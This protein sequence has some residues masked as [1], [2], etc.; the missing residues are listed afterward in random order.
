[1]AQLRNGIDRSSPVPLYHQLEGILRREI[2]SGAYAAGDPLPSEGQLG[3]QYDVSRSVV[4][5]TLTNLVDAGLVRTER[6]RG[7]F[8]A[9]RKIHE[10]FVQRAA[11]AY[12]DLQR[13]GHDVRTKVLRQGL[14]TLPLH[15]H[16]FLGTEL[17]VQIDRLRYI[18][19]RTLAY[20]RSY[21]SKERFPGIEE[22]DLE[23][24]SLYRHIE[25]AYG[26][27][28]AGGLRTVEAVALE[29]PIAGHL[30]VA[31]GSPSLML[32]SR[33]TDQFG[34]P[35]DWFDAWQRA[36]ATKFEF[37]MVPGSLEQPVRSSLVRRP[38]AASEMT[39]SHKTPA[40]PTS[41]LVDL[42]DQRPLV[43][44]RGRRY[45][46]LPDLLRQLAAHDFTTIGIRLRA[47]N[48]LAV[49]AA[50]ARM[51][52]VVVGACDVLDRS[53]A[54]A[55]IDAGAA[56]LVANVGSRDVL[57]EAEVP[58]MLTAFT[59]SEITLAN[60]MTDQPV[61][62]Y[63]ASMGGPAYVRSILAAVPDVRLIACGDV[64]LA[65]VPAFLE[66]GAAAVELG[67]WLCPATVLESGDVQEVAARAKKLRRFLDERR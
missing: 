8:V 36:D 50:A 22:A 66:A 46:H 17:G 28:P 11:G 3:D 20:I 60:A 49:L 44:L 2:D 47:E 61:A 10:R 53:L 52:G 16:E 19:G 18:D 9:E 45:D 57:E 56:F 14:V 7:S 31:P 48:G 34:E 62:L 64:A 15:V 6:G 29:D 35:L 12:D 51:D 39:T 67:E 33:S 65:D 37:E 42:D 59:P 25:D 58:V 5:Q 26:V 27:R 63:P 55:A 24:R 32:R 4:R 30:Q 23:D 13:M 54:R 1:M 43:V 21:L 40:A 41:V 38:D